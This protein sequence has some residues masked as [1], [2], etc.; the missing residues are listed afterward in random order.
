MIGTKLWLNCGNFTI[1]VF[2][3]CLFSHCYFHLFYVAL[4][5]AETWS[6]L[7]SRYSSLAIPRMSSW[8]RTEIHTMPIFSTVVAEILLPSRCSSRWLSI[9]CS[10]FIRG[11]NR[12]PRSLKHVNK[13]IHLINLLPF[14]VTP[15]VDPPVS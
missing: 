4:V 10:L 2:F 15:N 9:L 8:V 1:S 13:K 6:Y 12:Y 11:L 5:V 3:G 7:S 14:G